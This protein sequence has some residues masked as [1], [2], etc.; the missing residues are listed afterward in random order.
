M[1]KQEMNDAWKL[2]G[3][4]RKNDPRLLDKDLLKAWYMALKLYEKSEVEEAIASHFRES[5]F[6]PDVNEIASRCP[7]SAKEGGRAGIFSA[8]QIEK[9]SVE[10]DELREMGRLMDADYE[11][12]GIPAPA[13][14]KKLGWSVGAWNER[15]RVALERRS[16]Q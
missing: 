5:G 14:A 11:A 13:R 10:M 2:L 1:T 4:Y 15:C 12:V 3:K 7:S 8:A 16:D 9:Y 6:W